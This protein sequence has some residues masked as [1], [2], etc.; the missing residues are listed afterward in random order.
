LHNVS[1]LFL[2]DRV[3]HGYDK[4]LGAVEVRVAPETAGLGHVAGVHG[5]SRVPPAKPRIT[6][7][8]LLEMCKPANVA[9]VVR[10]NC[11]AILSDTVLKSA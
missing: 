3:G 2:R 7:K 5:V 10:A 4:N 11:W 1:A 6:L 8:P 9:P